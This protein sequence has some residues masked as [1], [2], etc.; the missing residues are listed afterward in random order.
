MGLFRA[1]SQAAYPCPESFLADVYNEQKI[2]NDGVV[3]RELVESGDGFLKPCIGL[4]PSAGV[5]C[6]I[7]GTDLVRDRDGQWYL[8]T[9]SAFPLESPTF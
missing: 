4:S 1:G 3:P 6:H 8:K 9:I 2:I 5:W 7:T